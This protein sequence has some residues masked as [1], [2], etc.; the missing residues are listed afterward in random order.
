MWFLSEEPDLLSGLRKQNCVWKE[1]WVQFHECPSILCEDFS[2]P[3][4]RNAILKR[5][6]CLT[7]RDDKEYYMEKTLEPVSVKEVI[8]RDISIQILG[9]L[10]W[11]SSTFWLKTNPHMYNGNYVRK[12]KESLESNILKYSHSVQ[13][14]IFIPTSQNGKT[15]ECM[16]KGVECSELL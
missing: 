6:N 1:K 8:L 12:R 3:S 14:I 11:F 10:K 16:G 15:T 13:R 5:T 2:G 4:A 7:Y 9:D